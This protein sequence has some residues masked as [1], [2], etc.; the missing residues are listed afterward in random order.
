[1]RSPNRRHRPGCRG[2][3][4]QPPDVWTEVVLISEVRKAE[5]GTW[6]MRV[7]LPW[8]MRESIFSASLLQASI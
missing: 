8:L 1:M 3:G 5:R 7:G 2:E 6:E 4:G